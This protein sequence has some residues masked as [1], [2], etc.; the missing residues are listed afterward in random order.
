MEQTSLLKDCQINLTEQQK[1]KATVKLPT[2]PLTCSTLPIHKIL[3]QQ[4]LLA[5]STNAELKTARSRQTPSEFKLNV[6]FPTELFLYQHTLSGKI[7]NQLTQQK[8]FNTFVKIVCPCNK[9]SFI[10]IKIM[11]TKLYLHIATNVSISLLI[12][13]NKLIESPYKSKHSSNNCIKLN[14]K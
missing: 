5:W 13:L 10:T 9:V 7:F 12:V 2:V 3:Y 4:P 1:A 6:L 11:R 14:F 8:F